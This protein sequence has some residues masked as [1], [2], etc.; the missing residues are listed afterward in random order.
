[1]AAAHAKRAS[2]ADQETPSVSEP[3]SGSGLKIVREK[4]A[5]DPKPNGKGRDLPTVAPV[6]VDARGVAVMFSLSVRT[7]RRLDSS[8]KI[9]PGFK[10]GGRKL[11]RL[12][13][14]RLWSERGFPARREFQ[15]YLRTEAKKTGSRA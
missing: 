14:L 11:W 12:R 10:I 7:V 15:D 5:P 4:T 9:P 3:Q 2:D 13:D 1:M 6:T 8:G